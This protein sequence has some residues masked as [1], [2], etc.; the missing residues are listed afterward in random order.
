MPFSTESGRTRASS[1]RPAN[2]TM[3]SEVASAALR[4]AIQSSPARAIGSR[5]SP[6]DLEQGGSLTSQPTTRLLFPSPRKDS[7]PK[8]LGEL[9][10]N[11]IHS[12]PN[13]NFDLDQ[14]TLDAQDKENCPPVDMSGEDVFA[15]VD[16]SMFERPKTP[17][18]KQSPSKSRF[19][20][21]TRPTPSHRPI[22]HSLTKSAKSTRQNNSEGTACRSMNGKSHSLRRSPRRQPP[23][24]SPF[25][26]A[27][28]K[29]MDETKDPETH[30]SPARSMNG[31]PLDLG[32]D[33]SLS[34]LEQTDMDNNLL[35]NLATFGEH[36]WDGL[37]T[38]APMPSS[39]PRGWGVYDKAIGASADVDTWSEFNG[40]DFGIGDGPEQIV[41]CHKSKSGHAETTSREL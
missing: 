18:S 24:E 17:P 9:T 25:T 20:T 2:S 36:P 11:V 32:I 7:S 38:D 3:T 5:K 35:F 27:L 41:L 15:L 31:S 21:S 22:T 30:L 33:F 29:L 8:I 1:V 16:A 19:K 14:T 39:P 4:R 23:A 13:V 10:T 37:S 34:S 40:L 26:A 12:K 28:N 6:I